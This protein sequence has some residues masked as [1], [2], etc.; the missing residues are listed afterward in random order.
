MSNYFQMHRYQLN[1][2]MFCDSNAVGVPWQ[3]LNHPNFLLRCIIFSVFLCT[4]KNYHIKSAYYN[5]CDD[6]GVNANKV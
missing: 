6:Y 4:N 2:A 1:V 5:I 3:H